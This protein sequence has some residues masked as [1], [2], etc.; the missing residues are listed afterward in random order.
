MPAKKDSSKSKK[1]DNKKPGK[2][3]KFVKEENSNILKSAPHKEN[4]PVKANLNLDED[5]LEKETELE[6]EIE[7]ELEEEK[8]ELEEDLE[9]LDN[10]D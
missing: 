1:P 7:V 10:I 9:D 5:E 2:N 6:T 4:Y 8:E 3:V